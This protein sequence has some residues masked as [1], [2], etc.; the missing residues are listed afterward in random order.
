MQVLM[1]ALR[2]C[3]LA[4]LLASA[5]AGQ[6]AQAQGYPARP[7]TLVVPFAPGGGTEVLAR[8]LAQRL[9]QRLGKPIVIE[10]KPGGGGVIG[11]VAVARAA[12]D[13]YTILMAP[14]PVMAINV[15]LHK[16]L[17]Y[18]PL[19]DFV[20]LALLVASPYVLVVTPSLPAQTVNELIALAKARP[21]RLAYASAG[22]GT[23]HHLFPELLKRMTGIEL[24]HVPYRGS[25]P[26]LTDVAA[27]HVELMFTDVPPA[28]GMIAESKVR[29]LAVSTKERV[30][31][32][33]EIKTIAEAGVPEFDAA[34]WQM[35]VAPAGT[36]PEIV[37]RLHAEIKGA[38]IDPDLKQQISKLGL[39][40]IDT[41]SVTSLKVFVQ[42]EIARWGAVVEQVGIAGSQ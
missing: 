9:E 12:P 15:T 14:S 10:N 11:A 7:V 37:E 1:Q 16:K 19:T 25:V 2:R 31:V 30:A 24:T 35:V 40:A 13:G 5:A 26:A 27:G 41:P 18:D 29:A 4:A 20:P 8:L 39:L 36:P 3:A 42:S 34:S 21:G 33:P 38:M 32:L 28:L 17:P 23:P 6:C 22:P